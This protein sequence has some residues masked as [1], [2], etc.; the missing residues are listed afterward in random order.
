MKLFLTR[1]L[2]YFIKSLYINTNKKSFFGYKFSSVFRRKFGIVSRSCGFRIE[3]SRSICER[4]HSY[5]TR[6]SSMIDRTF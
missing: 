4:R 2:I 1:Y 6:S 3:C 5:S